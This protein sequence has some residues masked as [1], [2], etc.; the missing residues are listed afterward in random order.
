MDIYAVVGLDAVDGF[1][2]GAPF[3]IG[4]LIVGSAVDDG[5]FQQRSFKGAACDGDNGAPSVLR[6]TH[7]ISGIERHP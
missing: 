4:H 1:N 5:A 6:F 2:F 7:G 3:G